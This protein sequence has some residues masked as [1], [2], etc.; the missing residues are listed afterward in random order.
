MLLE[1]GD[2]RG[3]VLLA[4]GRLAQ[5]VDLERDVVLRPSSAHRSGHRDLLGIDVGAGKAERLGADLGGTGGSVRAAGARGG[6]SGPC[7]KGALG[8]S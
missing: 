2:Q 6:T 1:V 7:S 8:P 3:A 4:L 5:A